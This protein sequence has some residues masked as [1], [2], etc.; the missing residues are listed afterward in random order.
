MIYIYIVIIIYIV[1]PLGVLPTLLLK[2]LGLWTYAPLFA[3]IIGK[4]V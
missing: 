3:L 1:I 2:D 4:K